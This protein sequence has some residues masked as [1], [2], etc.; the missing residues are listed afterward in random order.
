MLFKQIIFLLLALSSV[1]SSFNLLTN[2]Q[3]FKKDFLNLLRLRSQQHDVIEFHPVP[4]LPPLHRPRPAHRPGSGAGVGAGAGVGPGG[5]FQQTQFAV[6]PTV[7]PPVQPAV[8][9][10]RPQPR[11][12]PPPSPLPTSPPALSPQRQPSTFPPL[13]VIPVDGADEKPVIFPDYADFNEVLFRE[14]T[15]TKEF[16]NKK[17][18]I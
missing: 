16:H 11:P 5:A 7:Q 8:Q 10:S 6:V 4:Q 15:L 12:P 1:L 13:P 2:I 17:K 14:Q 9:P 3:H 18:K